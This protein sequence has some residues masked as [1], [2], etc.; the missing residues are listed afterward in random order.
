MSITVLCRRIPTRIVARMEGFCQ[1]AQETPMI[2]QNPAT[3]QHRAVVHLGLPC[4][5]FLS[6]RKPGPV[7]VEESELD[8]PTT[9]ARLGYDSTERT[10]ITGKVV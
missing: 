2:M 1:I 9:A 5:I 6:I 10:P 4:A 3:F 7:A 8:P